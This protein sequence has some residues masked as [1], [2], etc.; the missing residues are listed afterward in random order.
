[1]SNLNNIL[2]NDDELSEELLMKYA[3]G[4]LSAEERHAIESKMIDSSFLSDA[5]EGISSMKDKKQIQQYVDELN[6]QLQKQVQQKK[7]RKAKR[8]LP[9]MDWI[10]TSVIIVLLLCVLGYF[11]L[12]LYQTK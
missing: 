4:N 11:V 10:I 7:K 9:S 3:S 1:M 12:H 2:N 6:N 5:V 8:K